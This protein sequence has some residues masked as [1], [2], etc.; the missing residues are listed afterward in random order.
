[1]NNLFNISSSGKIELNVNVLAIPPFDKIWDRDKSKTKDKATMEI[2]YIVYLCDYNSPYNAFNEREKE[3]RIKED[4]IKD[5]EWIPDELIIEGI[6]KYIDLQNTISTRILKSAKIGAE[7]L[8]KYFEDVD[9]KQLDDNGK[10]IY[11]A[12]DLASN[13]KS[14][15]EIVKSLVNLE[16]QVKSEQ[17]ESSTVRG[18]S[19]INDYELPD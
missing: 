9:F 19:E 15:G 5:K 10:P 3:I 8:A 16:K 12:R 2:K 7:K 14:V 1:M 4:F 6:Q 17:L 11:T 18:N 13:L